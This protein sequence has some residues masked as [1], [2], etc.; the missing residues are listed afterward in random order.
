M[1]DSNLV[2]R[3]PLT[4]LADATRLYTP[5]WLLK[6]EWPALAAILLVYCQLPARLH[7]VDADV[8][9]VVT[10]LS[11]ALRSLVAGHRFDDMRPAIALAALYWLVAAASVAWAPDRARALEALVRLGKDLTLFVIVAAALYDRG[12]L[13][14]AAW[15]IVIAGILVTWAPAYQRFSGHYEHDLWGFGG[16]KFSHLWGDIEG[17]RVT[18]TLSDPNYFAQSLIPVLALGFGLFWTARRRAARLCAG[19]A[20]VAALGCVILTYS[21]GAV[22]ALAAVFALLVV[23]YRPHRRSAAGVALVILAAIP[24]ATSAY[25]KRLETFGKFTPARQT[26]VVTEPGF[27]GRAS[28][29]LAGIQMFKDHPLGGVG[30]GN[31]ETYYQ[32]YARSI[33]IDPRLEEREAHS[34]PIEIAAETG[35]VGLLGFGL[36]VLAIVHRVYIARR[37]AIDPDDLALATGIGIALSG[38]LTSSLFLHDAYQRQLWIVAALAYASARLAS[39]VPPSVDVRSSRAT[40]S[41]P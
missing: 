9:L 5:S 14:R 19:W 20:M 33:G 21:R 1:P 35:V 37:R 18:G 8:L 38:Y 32:R 4:R 27:R 30:L 12:T 17:Y 6:T 41:Q 16:T 39:P 13:R 25:V 2:T 15:A 40:V 28:E 24:F 11:L 34:L 36:L 22:I 23:G 10:V 3:A 31:Y 29:M 7:V 26:E